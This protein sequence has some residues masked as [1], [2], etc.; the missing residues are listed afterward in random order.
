L[1][2]GRRAGGLAVVFLDLDGFKVINDNLGHG[3]GDLL[4][5]SAGRRLVACPRPGDTVACFGGDEFTLLLLVG[6][7]D[8]RRRRNLSPRRLQRP[9]LVDESAPLPAG[10]GPETGLPA[11]RDH[12]F[13]AGPVQHRAERTDHMYGDVSLV[14]TACQ[15]SLFRVASEERART[16]RHGP[17]VPPAQIPHRR[18]APAAG[19]RAH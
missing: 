15:R 1:R 2:R 19:L 14:T 3:A 18:H 8:R 6:W 13:V 5:S 9:G 10:A 16:V 17:S 12:R 4:L 7:L 11:A